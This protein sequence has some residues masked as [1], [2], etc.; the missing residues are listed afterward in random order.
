MDFKLTEEQESVRKEMFAL[1]RELDKQKPVGFVGVESRWHSEE[2]WEFSLYCAKEFAKRGWLSLGWPAEYGGKGTML[3]RVFFAEARG[4]YDIPGADVF[5]VGMLAPTL[6]AAA[7]E[8]TKREFLPGIAAADTM[9]CELW[10]E[11]NAGSDLA[12]LTATAIR[13]GDEYVINGQKTWT[14]GAHHADW[15][16]G[17]FKTDPQGAKRHNLSFLLLDMKTP[18]ITINPLLYMNGGH[19][20]NE[21]FFDDVPV[22]ARQ[23]VG[24]ENDGWKVTQLL[25]GF[26]RSNMDNIMA[27]HRQ[28]EGLV[29]YCNETKVEGGPL[30]KN[31]AIRNSLAEI[32]CEIEADRVLAYRIADLQNRGEMAGFNASMVKVFTGELGERLAYLGTEIL[33]PYGQVKFSRWAP[34]E[35]LWESV[36]Q[37]CFVQSISMGTDEIQKNIM[38]WYGLGLPRMY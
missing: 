19:T 22:P 2:G 21:V 28:L 34:Q 35:G 37:Y 29:K 20:Y 23:I 7:S 8:E 5:G 16:F 33:G 25:A 3:N 6:I 15:G 4:Y 36:Y 18:G 10:S 31:P 9:W 12:A 1:C 38:A 11:P 13:K 17:I 24:A 30:A 26:E 32:A 14:S 27:M